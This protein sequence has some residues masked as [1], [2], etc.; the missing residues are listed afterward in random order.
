MELAGKLGLG[1]GG[2]D[3]VAGSNTL[4][5]KFSFL[6]I[7]CTWIV[8]FYPSLVSINTVYLHSEYDKHCY[9]ILPL[10]I[11]TLFLRRNVL[12]RISPS[13]SQFGLLFL[14]VISLGWV[15]GHV[16]GNFLIQQASV[17]AML[18]LFI[19][20]TSGNNI[21]KFIL[22]PL[23]LML[24]ALPVGYLLVPLFSKLQNQILVKSLTLLTV[25]VFWD[26]NFLETTTTR[27]NLTELNIAGNY[28]MS[29]VL[30]GFVLANLM[31]R[32]I[33]KKS[34]IMTSFIGLPFLT[35]L[36][37][38]Y[39]L[40]MMDNMADIKLFEADFYSSYSY[41]LAFT[42]AGIATLI[43]FIVKN[44]EPSFTGIR[45]LVWE[46]KWFYNNLRW[47]KP[48]IIA[49]T[50][51]L[52]TPWIAKNLEGMPYD[53]ESKIIFEAPTNLSN[54]EGPLAVESTIWDP[55]FNNT[56]ASFIKEYKNAFADVFLFGAYYY[57]PFVKS[58]ISDS[59]NTLFKANDWDYI[60]SSNKFI[61]IKRLNENIAITE[62]LLISGGLHR[63]IWS[64]YFV[65]NYD[66]PNEKQVAMYDEI[67]SLVNIGDSSGM[68]AIATDFDKDI[69][70]ARDALGD[71]LEDLAPKLAKIKNPTRKMN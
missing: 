36:I 30:V 33:I 25:P 58:N 60:K 10:S 61:K 27:F 6:V 22:F 52:A 51:I 40:I 32:S 57:T 13:S 44:T 38:I 34:I 45:D 65:G 26:N 3:L 47:L 53:G 41:I 62:T 1:R 71:F 63:I 20:I 42:G 17:I 69:E 8:T 49:C 14:F 21:V 4:K 37:G 19:L 35:N 50:I 12:D 59:G 9:F 70:K 5:A 64:W 68:I 67:R 48:T 28:L 55:S 11:L 24:F 15:Y 56:T 54:W 18:P 46:N 2:L 31:A 7:L 39:L 23:I 16:T 66:I 29:F 43:S